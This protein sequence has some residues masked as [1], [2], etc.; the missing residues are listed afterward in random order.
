MLRKNW[1]KMN[2]NKE[3]R[4]LMCK[5]SCGLIC[6]A[7]CESNQ[8]C[9]QNWLE[10]TKIWGSAW[11]IFDFHWLFFCVPSLSSFLLDTPSLLKE[12]FF[13]LLYRFWKI[14]S[15]LIFHF[16]IILRDSWCGFGA[17]LF[18]FSSLDEEALNAT[19]PSFMA[20]VPFLPSPLFHVCSSFS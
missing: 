8:T 19:Q 9:S 5:R 11:R 20:Q 10:N 6:Q 13:H 18:F 15:F 16:H 14:S 17:T 12:H 1:Q 4:Q 2:N 3:T 7:T